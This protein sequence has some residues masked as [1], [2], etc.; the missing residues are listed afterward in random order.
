MQDVWQAAYRVPPLSSNRKNL[1]KTG[2][3]VHSRAPM[4]L[5]QDSACPLK[6]E[7]L[8]CLRR[9]R[10][11]R[12]LL[13]LLLTHMF[14]TPH[15]LKQASSGSRLATPGVVYTTCAA[16][17]ASRA[18]TCARAALFRRPQTPL[19]GTLNLLTAAMRSIVFYDRLGIVSVNKAALHSCK[20][21]QLGTR[22][23]TVVDSPA[24]RWSARSWTRSYG[25]RRRRATRAGSAPR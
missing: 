13:S 19:D 8:H 3:V 7:G 4:R 24:G 21:Q 15:S 6:A 11:S 23:E 14:M 16:P 9:Q 5:P 25:N 17:Y 10:H 12:K 2:T 20:S 22:C 1:P 18:A